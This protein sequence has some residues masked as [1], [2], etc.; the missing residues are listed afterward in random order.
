[1]AEPTSPTVKDIAGKIPP[2]ELRHSVTDFDAKNQ[3]K[4]VETV[5]KDVLPTKEDLV[6][7]RT[8]HAVMEG[9]AHFDRR[10]LKQVEP[11]EKLPLPDQQ[12]IVQEKTAE[13]RD[14]VAKFNPASLKHTETVEKTYM[15][16]K[17]ELTEEK[18]A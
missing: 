5:E 4:H 17:E 1:M 12:A 8:E 11:S 2:A 6:K 18:K 7:E 15:P 3:L 9:V 16:S 10:S 14:E 13:I